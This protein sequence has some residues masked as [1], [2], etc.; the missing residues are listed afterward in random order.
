MNKLTRSDLMSLETYAAKRNEYRA[1]VMAHKKTVRLRSAQMQHCI[2][3]TA[4]P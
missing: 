3:K 2:L 1:E 4:S